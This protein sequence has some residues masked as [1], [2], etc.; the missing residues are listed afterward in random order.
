MVEAGFRIRANNAPELC[1]FLS[2]L[3]PV[4]CKNR[5]RIALA[6]KMLYILGHV[7]RT[8]TPYDKGK[9]VVHSPPASRT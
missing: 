4:G 9:I 1:A 7:A 6:R 5:A 2:R 8:K 3:A